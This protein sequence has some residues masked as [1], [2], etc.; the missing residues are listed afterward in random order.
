[1]KKSEE[2]GRKTRKMI[3][4]NLIVLAVLAVA[5]VVGVRS[6]FTPTGGYAVASGVGVSLVPSIPLSGVAAQN[7]TYLSIENAPEPFPVGI[8]YRKGYIL[9]RLETAFID[10]LLTVYSET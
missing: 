1:M 7:L 2:L 9:N 3:A 8:I 4:K 10:E 5:T 6:W